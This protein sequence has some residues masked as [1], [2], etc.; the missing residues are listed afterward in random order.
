[1]T[2]SARKRRARIVGS[3][4]LWFIFALWV[5]ISFALVLA[6]PLGVPW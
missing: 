2:E 4:I 1:M 5:G 6:W 3:R